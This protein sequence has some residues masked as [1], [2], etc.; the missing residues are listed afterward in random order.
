MEAVTPASLEEDA[1]SSALLASSDGFSLLPSLDGKIQ[2]RCCN[3]VS[4][5]EETV[6][7]IPAYGNN[8][9]YLTICLFSASCLTGAVVKENSSAEVVEEIQDSHQNAVMACFSFDAKTTFLLV[10][11]TSDKNQHLE[12]ASSCHLIAAT[13]QLVGALLG[14]MYG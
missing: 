11:L 7:E 3:N 13:I 6:T 4:T 5:K 8:I 9:A 2:Q 12:G 14:T 10:T 1:V